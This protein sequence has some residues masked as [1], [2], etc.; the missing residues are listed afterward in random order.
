MKTIS[1][2]TTLIL[3][4]VVSVLV[5]CQSMNNL[6]LSVTEPAAVFVPKHVHKIGI[7]NRSEST[8]NKT[9]DK[10]DQVFSIEGFNLDKEA[11]NRVISGLKDEFSKLGNFEK[12][13]MVETDKV[14]NPGLGIF[15]SSIPWETVDTIC[16]RNDVDALIVL[17]FY[18]TDAS[19][20]YDTRTIEKVNAFGIKIPFIEH[21]ATLTTN[22]KAGFRIYDNPSKAILDEAITNEWNTS[23]GRGINPAKALE[24]ITGRK[25]S[26]LQISTQIGENYANR[27]QPFRIRVW[28]E[29]YVRGTKNF[30]IGKRKAQTGDWNG[31]A[32]HWNMETNNSNSKIAGRACYNMGIINEINGDLDAAIK[33]VS[34]AYVEY[35]DRN[36]LRYLNIL[37]NRVAKNELLKYQ[38]N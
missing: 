32:E 31:A 24:A 1:Y 25:E 10:I 14:S 15:P 13:V 19:V 4:V 3:Y 23:I 2:K 21:S 16:Q 17:S 9:I 11:A 26:V 38:K 8:N 29:Y 37:K 27:T 18:D 34:K 36:A 6:T 30:E 35:K 12:I 7:L 28:R 20:A 22:I 33:W 5:A